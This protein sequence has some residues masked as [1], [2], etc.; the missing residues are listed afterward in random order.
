ML[1]LFYLIGYT[2]ISPANKLIRAFFPLLTLAKF[3]W[4]AYVFNHAYVTFKTNIKAD[5]FTSVTV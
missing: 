3:K 5:L 4:M 2:T 1:F